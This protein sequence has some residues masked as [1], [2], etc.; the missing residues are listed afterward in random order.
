M[1]D[2]RRYL[3]A[4]TAVVRATAVV[5]ERPDRLFRAALAFAK[6]GPT[7][8]G[9]VAAATAR[10]PDRRALV[11]HDRSLTYRELSQ[12]TSRL[13]NALADRFDIGPGSVV[14]VLCRNHVGFV[15][16]F[17]AASRL[18]ADVVLLNTGFAGPQLAD[19]VAAEGLDMV[20]HDD[21]FA[22]VVAT[23]SSVTLVD[24][25]TVAAL[26]DTGDDAERPPIRRP[27]RLVILTSGTTGRPRGANRATTGN[28]DAAAA[29]LE[30][31][32]LR[33]G[34]RTLIAAP[35]FHAWGLTNL[36][37]ALAMSSTVTLTRR[38]GAG[39]WVEAM[40]DHDPTVL[41]V[42]PV[43]LQRIVAHLDES[44]ASNPSPSLRIIASSGSALGSALVDATLDRFGPVLYNV[45]GSTEVALA[46]IATPGDLSSAPRTAG[47]PALGS[48][49]EVLDAAGD[50]VGAGIVGSVYVGNSLRFE[51]YTGGGT[52][53]M[54][55]GLLSTGD[56]GHFDGLGRLFVDGREDDMI[57]SGG[58]NVFS[59]EVEELLAGHPDIADV[60]VVGVAD[61]QFGQRL[62]AHV[63]VRS[64]R[65]L[66]P[67]DVRDFVASRLARFKVPRDV[68]FV[69][70]V[71]RNEAGKVMRRLL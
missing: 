19:V 34:D 12:R 71:P 20:I 16:A 51:G 39:P 40:S 55:H 4:A 50:A 56:L 32:P 18:G 42:V 17:L 58:E 8:S 68:V 25:S 53:A 64:G 28:V 33:V 37:F 38:G 13:A 70:E 54:R 36:L 49:V 65:S 10:Y 2:P 24:E 60:A 30:R 41:V 44:T 48:T 11:D 31:I 52:K 15:E 63:V 59:S 45:Y 26:V 69:D 27:G 21:E 61:D 5:P 6:S 67:A 43:I 66:S 23:A 47:R 9:M 35:L 57:V 62:A 14:G 22:D 3:N 29:V 46:T 7:L 1:I